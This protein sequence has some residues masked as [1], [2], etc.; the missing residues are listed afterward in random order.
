MTSLSVNLNKIAL[1]RNSRGR[2]YPNVLDYARKL[3]DMGVQGITVHPR[4]DERHI[5]RTDALEI[6][7]LLADVPGVEF[8]IEGYP[9]EDFMELVGQARPDQ[10]TL[11]PDS[12]DQLTSDHGWQVPA[13]MDTLGPALEKIRAAGARGALFLDPDVAQVE[14]TAASGYDRI[15]LYTEHYAATWGTPLQD[16]VLST[17][18]RAKDRAV[19]LGL[20]VNAGHDLDLRNLADFL[21]VGDI[22]EVSIGHALTVEAI[23]EGLPG[24]VAR[25]LAIC[26][27]A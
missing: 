13:S 14:A 10:V 1:L 3:I 19:L 6:G 15:E 27:S 12:V 24:V 2:D 23:D 21:S 20:G 16:T 5:K 4:Q 11:V 22:L 18:H 25:Y 26:S 8:N 17:Y 9:S 7:A